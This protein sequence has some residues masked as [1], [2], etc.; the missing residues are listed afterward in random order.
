MSTKSKT[1]LLRLWV[2]VYPA[3]RRNYHSLTHLLQPPT[4]PC[5]N[6]FHSH[7]SLHTPSV[8][9]S[10]VQSLKPIL[11]ETWEVQVYVSVMAAEL[12][13]PGLIL[14]VV[15]CIPLSMWVRSTCRSLSNCLSPPHNCKQDL[16]FIFVSPRLSTVIGTQLASRY[17]YSI[18]GEE[19][20]K[21]SIRPSLL[22]PPL[23]D[24]WMGFRLSSYPAPT[25]KYRQRIS[26]TTTR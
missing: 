3:S 18:E 13:T 5:T 7:D 22:L 20:G 4:S 8:D 11:K 16:S 21:S 17:I 15:H 2:L 14:H 23:S 24:N 10:L 12:H 6:P 26:E 25:C 1:A 9:E 19:W